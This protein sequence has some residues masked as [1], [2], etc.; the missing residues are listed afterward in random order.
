MEV[1]RRMPR[2]HPEKAVR[3]CD[4]S[5]KQLQQLHP[6]ARRGPWKLH[7]RG[8]GDLNKVEG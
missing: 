5:R 3:I 6:V 8:G 1:V 2:A 7:P 4:I